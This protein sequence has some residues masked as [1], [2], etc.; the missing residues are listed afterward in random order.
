VTRV[1]TFRVLLRD[2]QDATEYTLERTYRS[3]SPPTPEGGPYLSQEGN[4]FVVERIE[5]ET[6]YGHSP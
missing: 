1:M 3:L 6:I 5:G 2:G 4:V